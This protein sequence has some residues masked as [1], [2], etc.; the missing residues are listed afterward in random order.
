LRKGYRKT[1]T[2]AVI[3]KPPNQQKESFMNKRKIQGLIN[4]LKDDINMLKIEELSQKDK[5][6]IGGIKF[7]ID[8]LEILKES[9]ND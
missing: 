7:S 6:F 9:I 1:L 8:K 3:T 4:R 5:G 2:K